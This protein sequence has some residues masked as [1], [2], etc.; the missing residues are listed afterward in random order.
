MPHGRFAAEVRKHLESITT[1][2]LLPLFFVYSGLN[3]R[4]AL[5]NTPTLWGWTAVVI[6]LAVAGKGLACAVAAR[7]TGE[8]WRDAAAIGS[9]MNARGLVELIM[10][11]AGLEAG[12]IQPTLFTILVLM[13]VTTTV[14]ASPLFEHFHARHLRRATLRAVTVHR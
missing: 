4:I 2:L 9:L 13:A 1:T 10:L 12:I 3:T 7:L 8:S 11:N 14:M 6:L 5:L